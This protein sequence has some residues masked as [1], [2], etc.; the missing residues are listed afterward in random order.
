MLVGMGGG[1]GGHRGLWLGQVG[2]SGWAQE[3]LVGMAGSLGQVG[4]WGGMG[5]W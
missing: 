4:V 5:C 3:V 2:G 1:L